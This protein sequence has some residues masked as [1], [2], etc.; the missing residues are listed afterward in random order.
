MLSVLAPRVFVNLQLEVT[1][2]PLNGHGR[3]SFQGDNMAFVIRRFPTCDDKLDKVVTLLAAVESE[4]SEQRA[5]LGPESTAQTK[6]IRQQ[7]NRIAAAIPK[8]RKGA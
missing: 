5:E 3:G 4:V 8:R 2:R 7:L 1:V 6:Y